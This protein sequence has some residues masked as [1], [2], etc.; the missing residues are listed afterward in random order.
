MF[1]RILSLSTILIMFCLLMHYFWRDSS[2]SASLPL[3]FPSHSSSLLHSSTPSHSLSVSLC[4][5]DEDS[6]DM[7]S[8]ESERC[9]MSDSYESDHGGLMPVR[10]KIEQKKEKNPSMCPPPPPPSPVPFQ[11]TMC[12][13]SVYVCVCIYTHLHTHAHTCT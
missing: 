4:F 8:N 12:V 10:D 1:F 7:D 3:F 9:A 5:S 2:P 6:S 13:C 11:G